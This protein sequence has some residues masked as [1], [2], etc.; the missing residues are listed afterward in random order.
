MAGP[1]PFTIGDVETAPTALTLSA[2]SSNP[3]VLP[4]ANIIF[5]GSGSNRTVNL[6]PAT[7]QSGA[8]TVTVTV[9][10]GL[11]SASNTFV[12]TVN[13]ANTPPIISSVAD[14]SIN[15]DTPAGPIAFT[16]NDVESPAAS[17]T[18]T[19]NSSNPS[20]V[21]S[22]NF[23]FGGIGTNRTVTITPLPDQFGTGVIT[24]TVTDTNGATASASFTLTV[25]PV[26]DSP[27]LNPLADLA[28]N[29]DASPHDVVLSGISS[30]AAN[31]NQTLTVIATNNNIELFSDFTLT[32]TSPDTAGVLTFRP[33]ANASGSALV[34]VTV[35]D[36]GSSNNVSSRSFTVSFQ[37]T[38]DPPTISLIP[39]QVTAE[40]TPLSVSFTINDVETA[41]SNLVVTAFSLDSS[42]VPPAN[43]A[44]VGS[45]NN[46]A[47]HLLPAA[48]QLGTTI[49][50][51]NVS[52]GTAN[53]SASF[54]FTVSASAP[55][56]LQISRIDTTNRISFFS[57]SGKSYV[58]ESKV[59]LN[60]PS[61]TPLSTVPGTGAVVII[62]D[63]PAP[64]S[65]R[66]YRLRIE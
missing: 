48:N 3:T 12:L 52:D 16:V 32:Y 19:G 42:L 31:E 22:T 30:G 58:L 6:L 7:N 56:A 9:S 17:L 18:M 60:A 43:I 26:N 65:N 46:R 54:F 20:L 13:T 25:K 28:L 59:D 51:L 39:D 66:F 4:N 35:S 14:Q 50:V 41:A 29:E 38:N 55:P 37:P 34:T 2:N 53:T 45:G 64:E 33:A 36:G 44:L 57:Q 5:G 27:T 15:E 47:I 8:A 1:I 62:L 40:N 24:L 21:S 63:S 23:S 61:W 11:A 49:I 10:D